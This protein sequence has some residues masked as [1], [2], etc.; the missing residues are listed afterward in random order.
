VFATDGRDHL[1]R[2][3][4]T[5]KARRD[6]GTVEALLSG[7]NDDPARRWALGERARER[8]FERFLPDTQLTR[9]SAVVAGVLRAT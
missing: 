1:G 8:G 6:V 5:P 4:A 9:W 3:T 2:S 7:L